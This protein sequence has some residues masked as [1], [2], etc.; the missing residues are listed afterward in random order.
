MHTHIYIIFEPRK[1]ED[2]F[3]DNNPDHLKVI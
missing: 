2:E 3:V 1:K